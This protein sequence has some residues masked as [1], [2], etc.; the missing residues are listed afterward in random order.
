MSILQFII[1]KVDGSLLIDKTPEIPHLFSSSL[2]PI[3]TI[4]C[5]MISS[6]IDLLSSSRIF[7]S[8]SVLL[9]PLLPRI[10]ENRTS[11]TRMKSNSSKINISF[12]FNIELFKKSVDVG[13]LEKMHRIQIRKQTEWI[14]HV[15]VFEARDLWIMDPMEDIGHGDTIG[16]ICVI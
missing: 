13:S 1:R 10:L 15:S 7:Q 6:I 2:C 12:C 3:M 4:I 5:D 14:K 16:S 11:M 9:S 8:L